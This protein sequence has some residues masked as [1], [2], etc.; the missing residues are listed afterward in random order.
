MGLD[1]FH[2]EIEAPNVPSSAGQPDGG[3]LVYRTGQFPAVAAPSGD[4]TM[5]NA[6]VFSVTPSL[7][8]SVIVALTAA[9]I[10]A[11]HAT[12]IQGIP[13]PG[14]GKAIVDVSVV[15]RVR[16]SGTPFAA[17][18]TINLQ[19]RGGTVNPTASVLLAAAV[20]TTST[21]VCTAIGPEVATNGI[22]VPVNTAVD[23]AA[24]GTEYTTGT[25]TIECYIRYR[26][27]TLNA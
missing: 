11:L 23:I 16:S 27:I 1:R 20:T 22:A 15:Y 8:K 7:V 14:A 12:P 24:S 13:A 17:G 21:D 2:R 10:K 3:I 5:T 25:G 19:Y 6:G 18:S 9:Q 26:V 4:V